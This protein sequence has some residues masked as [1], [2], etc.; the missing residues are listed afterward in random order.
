MIFYSIIPADKVFE[1]STRKDVVN[2]YIEM[3][4]LGEKILAV[5]SADNG[6]VVGRLLSTSPKAYLD[7]RLQP[8]S[9]IKGR[10]Q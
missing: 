4:Y 1:D 8:G 7:P 3:E 5:P 10:W 6:L 9:A 2:R